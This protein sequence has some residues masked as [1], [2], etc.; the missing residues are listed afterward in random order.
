MRNLCLSTLLVL[1][2]APAQSEEF[3]IRTTERNGLA[4]V[5]AK[6]LSEQAGIAVKS[7][8]GQNQIAVCAGD[9]CAPLKEFVRDGP[10]TLIPVAALAEVLGAVA[11][12]DKN[13]ERVSLAF[14]P[15]TSPTGAGIAR[16]GQLAPNFRLAKLDG[17]S[18]ALSDFRG[19][20]VLINSWASW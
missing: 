4:Y 1:S 3:V 16:V 17:G 18:V 13:R 15:A 9:R 20:R 19:K 11:T 10:E 5:T 6:S 12:F 7:L 14:R 2:M 8:P